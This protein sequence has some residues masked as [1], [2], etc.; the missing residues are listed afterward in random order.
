MYYFETAIVRTSG[1]LKSADQTLTSENFKEEVDTK[2]ECGINKGTFKYNFSVQYAYGD[3][4]SLKVNDL[5]WIFI[6]IQKL[7]NSIKFCKIH[8]DLNV[9]DPLTKPLPRAKH[10][11]HQNSMGVRIITV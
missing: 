10:D 3:T 9:A 5:R 7:N 8:T 4:K 6:K 11:E 2:W 1:S